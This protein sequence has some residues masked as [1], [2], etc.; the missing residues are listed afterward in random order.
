MAEKAN[1]RIA[2]HVVS[3]ALG[4]PVTRYEDGTAN[5][6]VD[7]LI[8]GQEGEAALEIVADHEEGFNVQWD[9]LERVS[10]RVNVPGLQRVWSAQLARRAR[11]K[12]VTSVLSSLMLQMQGKLEQ[13]RRPHDL[14]EE[15]SRLGIKALYPLDDDQRSGYV[16]L[17]AEGWSGSAS[18]ETMSHYVERILA[19]APDVALKLLAHPADQKH[20]FIWTTIGTDYGIQFQLEFRDQPLPEASPQLPSG[21]THVW[22]VGSF[23][24]QG[25]VAWFPDLGWWRPDWAWPDDEI[26]V[27]DRD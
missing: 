4:V 17:H 21:V 18:S 27:A 20:A 12:D 14:P 15:F 8:H 2:R 10:H 19:R 3:T 6:Q 25:A 9:A 26:L 22:V 24:S 1:E 11:V 5:S 13:V 23:T 16:N 7:A